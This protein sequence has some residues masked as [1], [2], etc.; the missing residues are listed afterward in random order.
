MTLYYG[1]L[2]N[3]QF[4]NISISSFRVKWLTLDLI[5]I[6]CTVSWKS[7]K[8]LY[9]YCWIWGMCRAVLIGFSLKM[10]DKFVPHLLHWSYQMLLHFCYQWCKHRRHCP[11]SVHPLHRQLIMWGYFRAQKMIMRFSASY[12]YIE[13]V[14]Y[15]GAYFADASCFII[16]FV[17]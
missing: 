7:G 11:W 8:T 6:C 5:F 14:S 3:K 9:S 12:M 13:C 2:V 4:R 1:R 17:Y 16:W 15:L 10:D